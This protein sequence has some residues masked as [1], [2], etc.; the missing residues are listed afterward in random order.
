M[1]NQ[2][3]LHECVI[4]VGGQGSRLRSVVSDVPKP[5]ALIRE[6]PFLEYLLSF[7]HCQGCLHCV[8][9]VGYKYE[10][11]KNYFG[12]HYKNIKLDYAIEKEP[13]GT[14]GG[15]KNSLEF[16]TH[17]DFF[18]LN[19]DSF[20][21]VDLNQLAAFHFSRNSSI[22]LAVKEMHHVDRYGTLEIE[23][24]KI[25]RFNEKKMIERGFINAGVYVVSKRVFNDVYIEQNKFSFEK[26]VLEAYVHTLP[27]YA[28]PS[29]GYFI[30]VGIPEDNQK[31]QSELKEVSYFRNGKNEFRY[32]I[33]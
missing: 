2:I 10:V 7:L 19:G 33:R 6:K 18:L 24:D 31:A 1:D 28:F 32:R 30:D 3:K 15:I 26:D 27:Y 4:L 8:L 5:M 11:I 12:D 17:N 25:V 14:G 13:L 21:D 22:T 23:N 20:L 29:D 16:I 9:S